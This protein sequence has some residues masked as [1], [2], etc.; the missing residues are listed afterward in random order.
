MK[1]EHNEM[2]DYADRSWL[3]NYG[4]MKTRKGLFA[5]IFNRRGKKQ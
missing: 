2:R 3:L 1:T 5:R 4:K